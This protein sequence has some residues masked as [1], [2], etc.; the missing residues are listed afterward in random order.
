MTAFCLTL[1]D[2][3]AKYV[4]F[5]GVLLLLFPLYAAGN[6][7]HFIPVYVLPPSTELGNTKGETCKKQK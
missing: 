7:V 5:Q 3:N 2:T 1:G 6:A 4:F